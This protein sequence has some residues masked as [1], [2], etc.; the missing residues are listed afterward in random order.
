MDGSLSPWRTISRT[1]S[2]DLILPCSLGT[3]Q[4][5]NRKAALAD[6]D[7]DLFRAVRDRFLQRAAGELSAFVADGHIPA[8]Q[9]CAEFRLLCTPS[10]TR[11]PPMFTNMDSRP[12]P[13]PA[14]ALLI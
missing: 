5:F 13:G 6:R 2:V 12:A 10:L 1:S 11:C 8:I 14:V 3:E 7:V 4:N 9:R